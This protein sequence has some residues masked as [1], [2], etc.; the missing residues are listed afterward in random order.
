MEISKEL[1]INDSHAFSL[2]L[3]ALKLIQNQHNS[4]I[5]DILTWVPE[6]VSTVINNYLEPNKLSNSNFNKIMAVKTLLVTDAIWDNWELFLPMVQ[7]LNG[8]PLS[9]EV[10]YITDHPLPYLYNAINIMNIV[11]R[12]EFNEEVSRFCAAI[13]LHEGVFFAPEELSFCQL[14]ISQPRYKC[15]NCGK[16]GSALPPF[17]YI[18]PACS[19]TFD[20]S[21]KDRLFNFQPKTLNHS[22][23]DVEVFLENDYKDVQS[24]LLELENELKI[25]NSADIKENPIDIQCHKLLISIEYKDKQNEKLVKELTNY[26][27]TSSL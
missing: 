5:E 27:L 26:S 17:N 21:E 13:F 22:T 7:S 12:Q 23:T 1:F 8:L 11:R 24:R 20:A 3:G 16:Q 10:L 14:Y 9:R 4:N 19:K 18:C 25:K 6:T 2:F 15:K